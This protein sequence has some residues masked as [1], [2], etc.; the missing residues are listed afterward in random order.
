MVQSII[1]D[2][3]ADIYQLR[4]WIKG[5]SPMI[6]RRL[7]VKSN[8]TI[9]DLHYCIQIAMGWDDEHLHEF[10]IRGKSYGTPYIGGIDF[11]DNAKQ[12]YLS[13]FKF[14][15]KEKFTY[16]YNFFDHWKHEIRLEKQLPIDKKK[17]YPLCIGGNRCIPPEDCGGSWVFMGFHNG[18]RQTTQYF[19]F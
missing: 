18:N 9:A 19:A 3:P 1:Q 6:W 8:S 15:I 2:D 16:E 10:I 7:L 17:T 4:I 13:S 12:V 14:R 5:I 11:S